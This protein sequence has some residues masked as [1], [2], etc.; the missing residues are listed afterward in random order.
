VHL[1][2]TVDNRVAQRGDEPAGIGEAL[3]GDLQSRAPTVR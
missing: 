2:P 3:D 1:R